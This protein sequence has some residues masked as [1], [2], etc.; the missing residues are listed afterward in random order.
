ML[1][2][3]YNSLSEYINSI[4]CDIKII[5]G[6]GRAYDGIGDLQKSFTEASRCVILSEKMNMSGRVFWYEQMGIYNL[7][8][9]LA[10]NKVMQEFVDSTLGV[11]IEY[12]RNNN[13]ICWKHLKHIYGIITVLFMHL[14][15]CT[16]IE[17]LLS[18]ECSV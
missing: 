8:S 10:D 15:S 2:K 5:M 18:I 17:I 16:P 14:N 4:G 11:I 6:V 3:I 13:L 9:E 7:F 1:D 12:D